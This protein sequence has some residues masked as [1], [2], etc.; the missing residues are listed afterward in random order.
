MNIGA[1]LAIIIALAVLVEFLVELLKDIFEAVK[2]RDFWTV[3]VK[4]S[5]I[6][7]GESIA[8]IGNREILPLLGSES[9]NVYGTI[10]VVG[11]VI[12]AG[13]TKVFDLTKRLK[14]SE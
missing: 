5:A 3:A 9:F 13:S 10:A 14:K 2:T 8:F 1:L 7:I 4:I 6:A 12:S 11:L